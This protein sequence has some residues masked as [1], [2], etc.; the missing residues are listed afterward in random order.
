[1]GLLSA[2]FGTYGDSDRTNTIATSPTADSTFSAVASVGPHWVF[3]PRDK[4]RIG[5]YVLVNGAYSQIAQNTSVLEVEARM[6]SSVPTFVGFI[7]GALSTSQLAQST[8]YTLG[9][10]SGLTVETSLTNS[11]ALRI[12]LDIITADYTVNAREYVS[13]ADSSK[14]SDTLTA[15]NA[16]LSLDPSIALRMMF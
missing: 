2:N 4:V 13:A 9:V 16:G 6:T 8:F 7:P 14:S 1:M 10:L 12:G 3:N 11:I 15:V 5:S